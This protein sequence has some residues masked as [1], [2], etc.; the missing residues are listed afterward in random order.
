MGR[1][2]SDV[3]TPSGS[4]W[5]RRLG[6]ALILGSLLAGCGTS[7][8]A[9]SVSSERLYSTVFEDIA[10]VYLE[11]VE[12]PRLALAGFSGLSRIEPQLEANLSGD[13]V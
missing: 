3:K 10:E 7:N 6:A 8:H 12:I 2:A 5:Q 4:R 9:R 11:E 13:A 1:T